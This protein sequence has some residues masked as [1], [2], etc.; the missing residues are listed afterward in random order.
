MWA[1]D[2]RPG[3]DWESGEYYEKRRV[4]KRVNPQQNDSA[5]IEAFGDASVESVS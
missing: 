5:L 4:A 1:I 2:G 3:V